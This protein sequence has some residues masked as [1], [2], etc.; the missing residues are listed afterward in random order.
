MLQRNE[1][2]DDKLTSGEAA[3]I[4]SKNSGKHISPDYVRGLVR[5]G[6]LKASKLDSRTNLYRRGDVEKI[7]IGKRGRRPDSVRMKEKEKMQDADNAA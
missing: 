3:L 5:Q 1:S 6:R 7:V 2:P 4:L